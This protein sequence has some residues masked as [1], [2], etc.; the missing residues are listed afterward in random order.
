[1]ATR[2][3]ASKLSDQEL[4][5]LLALIGDADSVEMKLTLLLSDRSRAGAA[6]GVDPLDGK[7][8]QVYFFDTPDLALNQRGLVV[9][10]RRVQRRGGR[11]GR[12]AAAGGS[13]RAARRS[14]ALA[15]L[16]CRGRRD[17]RRHVRLLGIDE[18]HD[19][20]DGGQGRR[21]RQAAAQ[22]ALLEGAAGL[23][24]RAR[25]RGAQAGRPLDPGPDP[26]AEGEVRAGGIR[27]QARRGAV[28]LSRQLHAPRA[29]DEVRTLRNVPDRRRDESVPGATT[30]STSP[31]SR[32][33]RPRRRWSS[34]PN[35]CRQ[36]PSTKPPAAI[37]LCVVCNDGQTLWAP[38][39]I[40]V[41]G[42]GVFA[43]AITLSTQSSVLS[44]ISSPGSRAH[45]RAAFRA[46]R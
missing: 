16:R 13:R 19:G 12:E 21:G 37:P 3:V 10:A 15:E 29:V 22:E 46:C 34:S 30:A 45:A 2:A 9:R 20:A 1:M 5:E 6:L 39:R 11:L 33:P 31:A 14:A 17:A 44:L 40:E 4:S 36:S 28:A 18:A 26:G 23:V 43:I 38:G 41:L 24:C 8:R 27:P 42:D 35:G 32:Q 25:T 7:I